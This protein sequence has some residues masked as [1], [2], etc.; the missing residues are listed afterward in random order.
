MCSSPKSSGTTRK[1]QLKGIFENM[2]PSV[3]ASFVAKANAA[4]DR[5][6][7]LRNAAAKSHQMVTSEGLQKGK[8]SKKQCPA[9]ENLLFSFLKRMG[10]AV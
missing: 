2:D 4:Q 10:Y 7:T 6:N 8:V 3:R 9:K 5:R 1:S